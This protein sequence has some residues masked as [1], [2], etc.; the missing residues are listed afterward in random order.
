MPIVHWS[1]GVSVRVDAGVDAAGVAGIPSSV[2]RDQCQWWSFELSYFQTV[3][4]Q[5]PRL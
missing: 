4:S 3:D 1:S 2:G 5:Q